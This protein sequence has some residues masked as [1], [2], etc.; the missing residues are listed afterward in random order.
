MNKPVSALSLAPLHH[1]A[2]GSAD[3]EALLN[4]IGQGASERERDRI[5]P[6]G[7]CGGPRTNR[8]GNGRRPSPTVPTSIATGA[9]PGL[10]HRTIRR[11]TSIGQYEISGTLLPAKGFF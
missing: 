9:M 10:Y 3:L 6:Y 1:L 4:H 5:H 8:A 7:S 2:P 11:P